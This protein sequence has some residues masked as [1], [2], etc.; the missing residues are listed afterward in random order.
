M[1]SKKNNLLRNAAGPEKN[2]LLLVDAPGKKKCSIKK[3]VFFIF[4]SN[5]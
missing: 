4:G 2:T 3:M 1:P 5:W